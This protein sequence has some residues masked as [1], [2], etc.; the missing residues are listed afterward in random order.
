MPFFI[1]STPPQPEIRVEPQGRQREQIDQHEEKRALRVFVVVHVPS[2]RTQSFMATPVPERTREESCGYRT[3]DR[4]RWGG[5]APGEA[6]G[7]RIGP[8]PV[9]DLGHVREVLATVGALTIEERSTL[10]DQVL[11]TPAEV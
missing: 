3:R 4:A 9:A 5:G 1:A 6:S 11:A 8:D 7:G 10:G 2:S